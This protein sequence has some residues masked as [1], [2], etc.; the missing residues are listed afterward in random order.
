VA[1]RLIREPKVLDKTGWSHST[2]WAKIAEKKFPGPV[3]I[4]PDARAV[5][6]VED[7]IDALI[8]AA[9]ERRDAQHPAPTGEAAA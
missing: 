8:D 3:K 2:L 9:I 1:K 6:W 5:G 4:D 7:E